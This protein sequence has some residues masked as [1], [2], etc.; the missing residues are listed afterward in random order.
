M[1]HQITPFDHEILTVAKKS[2]TS[3]KMHL[4]IHHQ[5]TPCATK[6]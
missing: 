1:H 2:I 5:I 3:N 6:S 4:Y